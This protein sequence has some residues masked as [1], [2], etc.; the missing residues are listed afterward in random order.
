[1]LESKFSFTI[2]RL[3]QDDAVTIMAATFLTQ[4]TG[5]TRW[6]FLQPGWVEH[7]W[8]GSNHMNKRTLL[9]K[10]KKWTHIPLCHSAIH[11]STSIHIQSFNISITN[12]KSIT[13]YNLNNLLHNLSFI[14]ST[15]YVNKENLPQHLP[16]TEHWY[17]YVHSKA[18]EFRLG[19]AYDW[20]W[21]SI[22]ILIHLAIF[23]STGGAGIQNRVLASYVSPTLM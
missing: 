21:F 19:S 2:D 1:M 5:W 8:P 13:K 3:V 17:C 18:H 10:L 22:A 6:H 7:L 20:V 15:S 14:H 16:S 12:I 4:Q 11:L 9:Q 23:F